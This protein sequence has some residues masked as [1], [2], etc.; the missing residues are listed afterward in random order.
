[1]KQSNQGNLQRLLTIYYSALMGILCF[2]CIHVLTSNI[3]FFIA[4][5]CFEWL[6]F[7]Y[8][9]CVM[10]PSVAIIFAII[11]Y[12]G[13]T[14]NQYWIKVSCLSYPDTRYQTVRRVASE[15]CP[16]E[17]DICFF[18]VFIMIQQT[19]IPQFIGDIHRTYTINQ[20]KIISTRHCF[21]HRKK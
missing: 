17:L 12:G 10:F 15:A 14:L 7:M 8:Y 5:I 1:M 21:H 2:K 6:H 20:N 16:A 18:L 4:I 3:I 9:L 13:P 19:N 11:A